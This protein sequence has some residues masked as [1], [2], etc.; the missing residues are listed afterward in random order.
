MASIFPIRSSQG[1]RNLDGSR[2]T[3]WIRVVPPETLDITERMQAWDYHGPEPTLQQLQQ[4]VGG[5]IELTRS[6][7]Q[8]EAVP[9]IVNEE[10]LFTERHNDLIWREVDDPSKQP[11]EALHGTVLLFLRGDLS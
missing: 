2:H 6:Y 1:V 4:A 7:I 3:H 11:W 9:T 10:G 5:L 8:G